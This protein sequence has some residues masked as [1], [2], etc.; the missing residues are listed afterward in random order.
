MTDYLVFHGQTSLTPENANDFSKISQWVSSL[1][2][3]SRRLS[4]NIP[5]DWHLAY[6]LSSYHHQT[7]VPIEKVIQSRRSVRQFSGNPSKVSDLAFILNNSFGVSM[8]KD[9]YAYYTYPISGGIENLLPIVCITNVEGVDNGIYYY[10]SKKYQLYRMGDFSTSDYAQMTSSLSLANQSN[11]S[12]HLL[13]LS[14]QTCYKYQDR[15]YRFLLLECG[16]AM[17]TA[18]L[19]ATALGLGCI[20]SGG[21]YDSPLLACFEFIDDLDDKML[22]Y[23]CFIGEQ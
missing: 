22:L 11:F 9:D 2:D 3:F 13:V 8:I 21:G 12:I 4:F 10:E 6:D 18:C 14:N 1:S 20:V 15:G 17:Q 5:K 7:E 16:H 19:C 23:E